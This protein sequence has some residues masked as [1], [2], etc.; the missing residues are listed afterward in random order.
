MTARQRLRRRLGWAMRLLLLLVGL[1]PWL[2]PFARRYLPGEPLWRLLDLGCEGVCHR[3]AT[4]TLTLASLPMPLCSRC[5]GICAGLG[6]GALL[7]WPRLP[8]S[9]ARLALGAASL[10]MLADVVAQDL[11][12][13]PL[14]H[15]SRLAT[16]ALVG[17][18]AARLIVTTVEGGSEP[19]LERQSR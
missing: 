4:R 3:M 12:W 13:H 1:V 11:A 15:W 19:A 18:L 9:A 6:L 5:A 7:G 17:Y 14:W 8:P 10:V 2:L 16:G